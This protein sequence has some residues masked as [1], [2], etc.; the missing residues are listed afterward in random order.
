M[1]S[2]YGASVGDRQLLGASPGEQARKLVHPVREADSPDEALADFGGVNIHV[3]PV[4]DGRDRKRLERLCRCMARP[5]VCQERLAVTES[6][7]VVVRFKNAWR[8]GAHA[9]GQPTRPTRGP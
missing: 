9:V 4:I 7:Q 6:G 1:A 2:C 3:G 5:P 8:N